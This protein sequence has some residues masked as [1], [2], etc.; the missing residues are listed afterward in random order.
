MNK[1]NIMK[2]CPKIKEIIDKKKTQPT[3]N[4]RITALEN[5]VANLAIQTMGVS[6]NE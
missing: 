1:L 5:A 4:E 6:I 3:T 2:V